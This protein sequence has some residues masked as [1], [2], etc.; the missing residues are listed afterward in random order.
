MT[1]DGATC[2]TSKKDQAYP[3]S[4]STMQPAATITSAAASSDNPPAL[5]PAGDG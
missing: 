2:T 3:A 1:D 5:I 4:P